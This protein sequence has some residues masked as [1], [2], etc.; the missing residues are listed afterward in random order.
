MAKKKN[1]DTT[2]V[3]D[4][5]R[6]GRTSAEVIHGTG[7]GSSKKKS[8]EWMMQAI[9]IVIAMIIFLPMLFSYVFEL[10]GLGAISE[11]STIM[12]WPA[13][14]SHSMGFNAVGATVGLSILGIL[15]ASGGKSS[16]DGNIKFA[17]TGEH[18]DARMMSNERFDE[19]YPSYDRKSVE[20]FQQVLEKNPDAKPDRGK[21]NI[22]PGGVVV[23][24]VPSGDDDIKVHYNNNQEHHLVIGSTG[25]GKTTSFIGPSILSIGNSGDSMIIN[26]PKGELYNLYSRKLEKGGYD[27]VLLNY[28]N[29]AAGQMYNQLQ[30]INDEFDEAMPHLYQYKATQIML[31]YISYLSYVGTDMEYILDEKE[32]DIFALGAPSFTDVDASAAPDFQMINSAVLKEEMKKLIFRQKS[33]GNYHK[34]DMVM[35][36]LSIWFT[37]LYKQS[38]EDFQKAN[39]PIVSGVNKNNKPSAEPLKDYVESNEYLYFRQEKV[40]NA[41]LKV[42]KSCTKENIISFF[43]DMVV[44]FETMMKKSDPNSIPYKQ[45][46]KQRDEYM[47]I[48]KDVRDSEVLSTAY[49][50]K[51]L[52]EIQFIEEHLYK[53]F[54]QTAYTSARSI[55]GMIVESGQGS[56]KR[57]ESIWIDTP[58]ALL[59]AIILFVCRESHIPN[60][61]H[62]GSVYRILSDMFP[63]LEEG[64]NASTNGTWDYVMEAYDPV[65]VVNDAQTA[66]KMASSNTRTSVLVS[67]VTP[68][69]L[70][71]DESVIS[72]ASQ[73]SIDV[74]NI[75]RKPTAI[76][77]NIPGKD[78]APTYTILASLFIEQV[79]A[80]LIK[81]AKKQPGS[82][83]PKSVYLL[84]DEFG[85]M[86]PIPNMGSKISLARSYS[87]KF[88]MIIQDYQQFDMFY[89][90][91]RS[92]ITSNANTVYL[93]TNDYNTA[94]EISERIGKA[95]MEE[96]VESTSF[97][98]EHENT[99]VNRKTFG[100]HLYSPQALM[101]ETFKMGRALYIAP[102]SDAKEITLTPFYQY[103]GIFEELGSEKTDLNMARPI[104][105][106][107]RFSPHTD[108]KKYIYAYQSLQNASL[109]DTQVKY[110]MEQ[111]LKNNKY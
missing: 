14:M 28:E 15:M 44:S 63:P 79:Y 32:F 57:G 49:L 103:P 35:S 8:S 105:S 91:E 22:A 38:F 95:T 56:G 78:S 24:S 10:S 42:L 26:D 109:L 46:E 58:K 76:F 80:T 71:A 110:I 73:S 85:N 6:V 66:T 107:V 64:R 51:Y 4:D 86:P 55:A 48:I 67:A 23:N 83:L 33:M 69:A 93:L 87:I 68:M 34:A 41:G 106:V 94:K 20:T 54:Q 12:N 47:E 88:N 90:D 30:F 40:I 9:V 29:P 31:K 1:E 60:T 36:T 27:V 61:R 13:L 97:G 3:R 52:T 21:T 96:V 77:L 111:E 100:Y 59:T 5:G 18:G 19:K 45:S 37:K 2:L 102:R 74:I 11:G 65:D 84:L 81:F 39:R 43:E 75:V 16:N 92:T 62:L 17:A 72:Q 108:Y 98:A 104:A 53:E 50:V 89:K 82:T 70:F 101:D 99:S 7:G 25:S